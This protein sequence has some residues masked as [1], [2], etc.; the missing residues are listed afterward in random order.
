[1]AVNLCKSSFVADDS[2]KALAKHC[3][4]LHQVLKTAAWNFSKA[5]ELAQDRH[6][7]DKH[8]LCKWQSTKAV[9]DAQ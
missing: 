1:M 7:T 4:F 2:Q 8:L 9:T 6:R 3:H 5:E